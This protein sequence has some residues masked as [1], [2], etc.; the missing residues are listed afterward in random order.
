M[1]G[2][3]M[4][5]SPQGSVCGRRSRGP[6]SLFSTPKGL[7]LGKRSVREN[8]RL[9]GESTHSTSLGDTRA[10]LPEHSCL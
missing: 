6:C 2:E 5:Q 3:G 8:V 10:V 1:K 9:L 4:P 7:S